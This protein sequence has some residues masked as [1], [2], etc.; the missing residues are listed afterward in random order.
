MSDLW[1]ICWNL[2]AA[3][4]LPS[5]GVLCFM[6]PAKALGNSDHAP[7]RQIPVAPVALGIASKR[8]LPSNPKA[9]NRVWGLPQATQLRHSDRRLSQVDTNGLAET[10]PPDSIEPSEWEQYPLME[11]EAAERSQ[12]ILDPSKPLPNPP[13]TGALD[14]PET[15]PAPNTTPQTGDIESLKQL[16]PSSDPLLIQ[17]DPQAVEV[18]EIKSITLEQA[19]ALAYLN[20]PDLQSAI[21]SLKQSREVL[22]EA[23]ADLFPSLSISSQIDGFNNA[24]ESLSFVPTPDGGLGLRVQANEKIGADLSAR[25]DLVYQ[26]Y[27]SGGRAASIRAAKAQV[28]FSELEVQRQQEDL[29]L[30][31]TNDYYDLQSALERIR[32][33]QAFLKEAE[34]NL[35]DTKFRQE[36]G[37]GTRFDVLRASV[38]AAT[39]RQDVVNTQSAIKQAREALN[40]RL[41][42]PPTVAVTTVPVKLDGTWTLTLEE[43]L[44]LA[45]QNRAELQQQL[46]QREISQQ[47]RRIA[48]SAIGPQ[49]NLFANYGLNKILN[50]SNTF[51]DDYQF[52]A[53]VSW[54][55]FDGGAAR[56]QAAQ[57]QL[58]S[59][60]AEQNFATTRN[61][62]RLQVRN[63]YA[64]LEANFSNIATTRLAVAEAEEAL[65]LSI[66]RFNAG[67]GTQLD[68]L[69]SQSQLTDAEDNLVETIVGYNR[70]IARLQRAIGSFSEGLAA[71]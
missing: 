1:L 7:P 6:L 58:Q 32:I 18:A 23:Q 14:S 71:R 8:P 55:L 60:I 11:M 19:I 38:Q 37:V 17:T 57:Q 29:R 59:E 47:R 10:L 62:I 31:V 40:S 41:N 27:T 28:Q 25:A 3:I 45:Y 67:V 63:A 24:S 4:A 12:P 54:S 13:G 52:G 70:S 50:Q 34:R 9:K 43:S 33:N 53:Q 56:A 20:N 36:G 48:L 42:L 64:D 22:R 16:N 51:Q 30:S 61:D 66:L 5:L 65:E 39:A 69:S 2:G 15:G 21:L 44:I 68:V 46:A 49:L 35:Q 26:L